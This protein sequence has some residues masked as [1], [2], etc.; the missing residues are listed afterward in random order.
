MKIGDFLLENFHMICV[1]TEEYKKQDLLT[2]K[3][4]IPNRYTERKKRKRKL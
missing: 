4:K 3:K 2:I 1:Q